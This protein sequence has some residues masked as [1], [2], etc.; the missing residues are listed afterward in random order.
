M[1]CNPSLQ[2]RPLM[3]NQATPKKEESMKSKERH[4]GNIW[5]ILE[6]FLV[7]TLEL[8]QQQQ[9][10][11]NPTITLKFPIKL[12]MSPIQQ[13]EE[14]ILPQK[15]EEESKADKNDRWN[16]LIEKFEVKNIEEDIF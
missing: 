10:Q 5:E 13:K 16:V 2:P 3:A 9:Q 8:L 14:S 12:L 7:R 1:F 6:D 15:W 11:E 4:I